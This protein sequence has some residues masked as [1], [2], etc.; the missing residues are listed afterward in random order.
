MAAMMPP[1]VAP[2]LARSRPSSAPAA[3]AAESRCDPARRC[4]LPP[5]PELDVPLAAA[6]VALA[7]I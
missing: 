1:G 4:A 3:C 7:L 6:L 5:R 2:A